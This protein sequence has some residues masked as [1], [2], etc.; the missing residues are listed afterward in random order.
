MHWINNINIDE[1]HT[2]LYKTRYR[3]VLIYINRKLE[4]VN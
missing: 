3:I 2:Y 1:N 4:N